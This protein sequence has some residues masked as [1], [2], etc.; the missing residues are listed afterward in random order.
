MST[1]FS[2]D[3][4][5]RFEFSV[6]VA[7]YL[8][9]LV[10]LAPFVPLLCRISPLSVVIPRAFEVRSIRRYDRVLFSI[11][12]SRRFLGEGRLYGY[13]PRVLLSYRELEV[14]LGREQ[15]S[16]PEAGSEHFPDCDDCFLIVVVLY[17]LPRFVMKLK[18]ETSSA[19]GLDDPARDFLQM[20]SAPFIIAKRKLYK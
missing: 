6:Q 14:T 11:V 18:S 7:K 15:V 20:L 19:F 2:S 16:V 5:L 8:D 4:P 17:R 13:D 9:V 1:I 10:D 3:C 12:R